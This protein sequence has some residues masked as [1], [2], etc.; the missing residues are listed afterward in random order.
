M[1]S[2]RMRT[3][4]LLTVSQHELHGGG[5]VYPSMHWVEGV[6]AS[7]H[8]AGGGVSQHALGGGVCPG[9]CVSQHALGRGV[10][11]RVVSAWGGVCPGGGGDYK[12]VTAKWHSHSS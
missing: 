2:S 8:W 12:Q 4:R 11:A 3:A 9:V 7:M 10:S 1:H 5:G 6:Y